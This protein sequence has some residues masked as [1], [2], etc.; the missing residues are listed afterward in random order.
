MNQPLSSVR[1]DYF[2]DPYSDW[3]LPPEQVEQH[4][5]PLAPLR[6]VEHALEGGE[7]AGDDAYL[8][9]LLVDRP[10]VLGLGGARPQGLD[11]RFRDR[12]DLPAEPD[13]ARH[14]DSAA[15]RCPGQPLPRPHE[16]IPGEERLLDPSPA[17]V[18][19]LLDADLGAEHIVALAAQVLLGHA[20]LTGLG[21]GEQP[22]QGPVHG[23]G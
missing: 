10:V 3:A 12:G 5:R 7:R 20:F 18:A 2:A 4:R 14:P 13:E 15:H 23:L 1:V 17:A 8:L 9:A 19:Q 11:Q 6:H 21:V 22:V 16:E